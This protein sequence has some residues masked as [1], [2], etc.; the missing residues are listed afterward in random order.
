MPKNIDFDADYFKTLKE[1]QLIAQ[2][3]NLRIWKDFK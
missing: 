1:G 2:S 3:K